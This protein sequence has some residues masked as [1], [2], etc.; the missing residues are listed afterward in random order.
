MRHDPAFTAS[1]LAAIAMIVALA[2]PAAAQLPDAARGD[3]YM[4]A[5]VP[6]APEDRTCRTDADCALFLPHCGGCSCGV[7]IG[8]SKLQ[9]YQQQYRETCRLWR[10]ELCTMDCPEIAP[11]CVAGACRPGAETARPGGERD[12]LNSIENMDDWRSLAARPD[13]QAFARTEVVKFVIDTRGRWKTYLTNT[14]AWRIHYD[15]TE[16]LVVPGY[17][18][19]RF[20]ETEYRSPDRRFY[21]GSLVRYI[22]ADGWALEIV[23]GDT[24]TAERIAKVYEHLKAAVFFGDEMRFRPQSPL[25]ETRV[26]ELKQKG[27]PV[28]DMKAFQSEIAYQ[29]LSLGVSYGRLRVVDGAPDPATVKPTDILLLRRAPD[30][31]PFCAGLVTDAYQPFL[32]HVSILLDGRGTPNMSL[33]GAMDDTELRALDGKLVRLEVEAQD[34]DIRAATE[35]EYR[36]WRKSREKADPVQISL[37][38]EDI[39]LPDIC[40]IG[41]DDIGAVGGKAA[42]LGLLCGIE[43]R[44]E[45]PGGFVVPVYYFLRHIR[46][47]GLDGNVKNISGPEDLSVIRWG[48]RARPV[49]SDLLAAVRAKMREFDSEK[50][51]LR[52]STNIEDIPGFS[53]AGLYTSEIVPVDADDETLS[54]AINTV[55]A[56]AWR[57]RAWAERAR[58]GID[59]SR[60]GMAVI[61]QPFVQDVVANGVAITANPFFQALPGYFINV[62]TM[63]GSVTEP[64]AGEV[65]ESMV[66]YNYTERLEPN[67]LSR[68]SLNGGAPVLGD[69][70]IENLMESLAGIHKALVPE[71]T[72]P[73]GTASWLPG[74]RAADVE[75]LVRANGDIVIL[76]A[77]P[78]HVRYRAV[79]KQQKQPV[80]NR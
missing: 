16:A 59:Q 15:F 45:T 22:D 17:D 10:G 60:T 26:P 35:D 11:R 74:D 27:V 49:W 57:E 80:D 66:V 30:D 18:H 33:R 1:I 2:A 9:A 13:S 75:F 24:M 58:H 36:Q 14:R 79:Y 31:L 77:R 20:N 52:S 68:S 44:I 12:F 42:H 76:Q 46:Q 73:D 3:V 55:W 67:V 51:I 54:N 28:W 32:S 21:M 25:H 61:V 53:G 64:K 70:A 29:P 34:Y 39:G 62:Q 7:G 50:V 40:D 69:T 63:D 5:A 78:Y 65:P 43:P 48:M 19:Y 4:P 37:V 8:V 41:M 47:A 6:V 56:S 23:P 72:P 71:E 38:D